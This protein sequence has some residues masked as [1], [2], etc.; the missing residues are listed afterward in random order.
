MG[1]AELT[2][3]PAT[4]MAA[5]VAGRTVSAREAVEAHLRRIAAVDDAVNAVVQVDAERA[6]VRAREADETLAA[7]RSWGPLHG[8]PF[9]VKD[10]ISAAGVV[11]AIGDPQRAGVV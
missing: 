7:G 4:A 9:S 6:L 10:N 3:A 2:S 11:M 8:V 5:L 1:P